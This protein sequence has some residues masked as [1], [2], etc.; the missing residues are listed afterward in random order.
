M[1]PI[2]AGRIPFQM[3]RPTVIFGA[4]CQ[5][6][7]G[8]KNMFATTWSNPSDMNPNV[9]HQMPMILEKPSLPLIP[10]NQAKLAN[11][12]EPMPRTKIMCHDGM[13]CFVVANV[14]ASFLYS[15]LS[16]TPPKP[17]MMAT[18][19]SEPARFPR[20]VTSQ[21]VN[22]FAMLRRRCNTATVVNYC[23]SGKFCE[24]DDQDYHKRSSAKIGACQKNHTQAVRKDK[25]SKCPN[26][27]RCVFLIPGRA[28]RADK[29][30][31]C[32]GEQAASGNRAEKDFIKPHVALDQARTGDELNRFGRQVSVVGHF[33]G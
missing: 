12:F 24:A 25:R 7:M 3:Y 19:K 33:G 10:R 14:M 13:T 6:P 26:E 30:C 5:I 31:A 20:K 32:E 2:R 11:Q 8:T 4:P 29:G 23:S 28:V 22:I 17:A 27:A 9:G 16:N 15:L 18:M 1:L 21:W